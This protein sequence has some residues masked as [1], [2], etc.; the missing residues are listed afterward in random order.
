VAF[1]YGSLRICDNLLAGGELLFLIVPD[2]TARGAGHKL[3]LGRYKIGIR[4]NFS[5]GAYYSSGTG[6]S[7]CR[8]SILRGFQDLARQR[9]DWAPWSWWHSQTGGRAR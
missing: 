7:G 6:C 1:N 5:Q 2:D 4:K 9:C 3:Q 8:I